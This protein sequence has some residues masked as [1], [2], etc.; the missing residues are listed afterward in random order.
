M[1]TEYKRF[2]E[3]ASKLLEF[4]WNLNDVVYPDGEEVKSDEYRK[5]IYDLSEAIKQLEDSETMV[6]NKPNNRRE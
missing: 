1:N 3:A 5:S 2:I 4:A 6:A